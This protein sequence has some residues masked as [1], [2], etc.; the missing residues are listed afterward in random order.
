LK[1]QDVSPSLQPVSIISSKFP[2]EEVNAVKCP[3]PNNQGF[4]AW[5]ASTPRT[6]TYKKKRKR[7]GTVQIVGRVN[8]QMVSPKLTK[9]NIHDCQ[10]KIVL[11]KFKIFNY[12]E[13]TTHFQ[14]LKKLGLSAGCVCQGKYS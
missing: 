10:P 8:R 7:A 6:I 14:P 11:E 3:L 5:D 12:I 13:E 2:P 1:Q 4:C 9:T